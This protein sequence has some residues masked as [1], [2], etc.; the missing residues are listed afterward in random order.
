M[1]SKLQLA[2]Q[3]IRIL[4]GGTPSRDSEF[5]EGHIMMAVSQAFAYAVKT[6]LFQNKAEGEYDV[7]GGFIYSFEG[8][9]SGVPIQFD[10]NKELYYC[11]M[12]A[13]VIS[14]PNE[15]GISSV[16]FMHDLQNSF[17]RVP[18]N[19]MS[20]T[21][22]REIRGLQNQKPYYLEN[23]SKGGGRLYFPTLNKTDIKEGKGML[24]RLVAAIQDID[25][26][27]PLNLDAAIQAEIVQSV[28]KLYS[29]ENSI[30]KDVVN[31]SK[32]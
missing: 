32:P 10:K 15:I 24:L 7:S 3:I 31:D 17:V 1:T 23:D 16:S 12:P 27:T 9:G 20:L 8:D 4:S 6:N 26:D 21:K 14:L 30:P 29:I 11:E 25:E 5:S 19:F 28:V 18:Y 22:G 13:S 2:Q